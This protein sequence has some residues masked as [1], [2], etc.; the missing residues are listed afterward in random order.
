MQILNLSVILKMPAKKPDAKVAAAAASAAAVP[1]EALPLPDYGPNI[2]PHL[3]RIRE[4]FSLFDPEHSGFMLASDVLTLL[5]ALGVC[6]TPE[7]FTGSILSK[8]EA[9]GEPAPR[10]SYGKL[11]AA[12]LGLLAQRAFPPPT[13]LDL[14][15]A[16]RALDK[17]G[18]GSVTIDSL[19]RSLTNPAT[20]GALSLAE[21]DALVARLP[22]V[23]VPEGDRERVSYEH[24]AR[25][26]E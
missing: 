4:L 18:S 1:L 14:L 12:A 8:L 5:H 15:A 19:R 6:A 22:R 25:A 9:A 21:F 24:Y 20:P 23:P 7:E 16:F 11:E 26:L 17:E 3:P 13:S 2:S 10:V